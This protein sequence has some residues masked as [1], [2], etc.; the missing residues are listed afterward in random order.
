[1]SE[2]HLEIRDSIVNLESKISKLD[3]MVI[4]IKDGI[5]A[6]EVSTDSPLPPAVSLREILVTAPDQI[7]ALSDRLETTHTEL[8]GL[9]FGE[10]KPGQLGAS[11]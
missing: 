9:L 6:S 2:L 11:C 8:L 10:V 3:A 4:R 7:R 5:K 1:M